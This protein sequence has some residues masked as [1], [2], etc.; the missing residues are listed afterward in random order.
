MTQLKRGHLGK[1]RKET[2]PLD[3]FALFASFQRSVHGFYNVNIF[4]KPQTTKTKQ[5]TLFL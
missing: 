5:I 4:A 1:L 3:P 2:C